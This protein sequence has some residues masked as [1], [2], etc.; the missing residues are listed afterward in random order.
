MAGE[1]NLKKGGKGGRNTG[2]GMWT[3]REK[4]KG[5]P[6]SASGKA[7]ENEKTFAEHRNDLINGGGGEG[8]SRTRRAAHVVHEERQQREE[9]GRPPQNSNSRNEKKFQTSDRK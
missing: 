7:E 3:N 1:H 8:T 5:V 4:G 9:Q 6:P 2:T